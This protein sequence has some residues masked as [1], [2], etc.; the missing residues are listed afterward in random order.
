LLED[1]HGVSQRITLAV[2][3]VG[4]G[5]VVFHRPHIGIAIGIGI[6][7]EFRFR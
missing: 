6:D 7:F 2:P 5:A 3:W 1:V 4:R